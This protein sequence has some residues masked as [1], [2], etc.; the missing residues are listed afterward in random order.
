LIKLAYEKVQWQTLQNMDTI[1][2]GKLLELIL[3][4]M[5][6]VNPNALHYLHQKMIYHQSSLVDQVLVLLE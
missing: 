3:G 5:K 1:N 4:S 6:V 2:G